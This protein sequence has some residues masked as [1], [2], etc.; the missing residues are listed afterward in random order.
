[1]PLSRENAKPYEDVPTVPGL[2]FIG[3]LLWY[4]P[5]VGVYNPWKLHHTNARKLDSY[6]PLI[7]ETI[8]GRSYLLVF[9]PAD[10][11]KVFKCE[12][13]YPYRETLLALKEYRVRRHSTTCDPNSGLIVTQ[14]QSWLNCRSALNGPLLK[15]AFVAP[16][17]G[18]INAVA[19]EA[20]RLLGQ[21][22]KEADVHDTMYLWAL[23]SKQLGALRPNPSR[24]SCD[25]IA[26][27]RRA[28]H[29]VGRLEFPYPP[30]WRWMAT[31]NWSEFEHNEDLFKDFIVDCVEERLS[32][33]ESSSAP[34]DLLSHIINEGHLNSAEIITCL[35]DLVFAAVDTTAFAA[36]FAMHFLARHPKAQELAREEA[37]SAVQLD[38]FC[39]ERLAYIRAV[40]K[41]TLRLRPVVPGMFRVTP[42]DLVLSGYHVPAGTKIFTQNHVASMQEKHFPRPSEFLP[43]RWL[44]TS[45]SPDYTSLPFGSGARACIGRR[46]AETALVILLTR[47]LQSFSVE[48]DDED[49]DIT[50][51]VV[52]S[53]EKPIHLRFKSL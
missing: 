17:V 48:T 7:R 43:E 34:G 6:G 19:L 44:D 36:S 35:T 51:S 5:Y 20:T 3:T 2:P 46:V 38:L 40:I 21:L 12:S 30:L 53:P 25:T 39:C 31:H 10:I 23:E 52:S 28:S 27:I 42:R 45:S 26:A 9:D 16:H 1:M 47:V 22:P 15:T 29:A 33:S 32:R 37:E 14:G 24:E 11:A 50:T 41:E 49:I 13:K 4:M 18:T 8:M